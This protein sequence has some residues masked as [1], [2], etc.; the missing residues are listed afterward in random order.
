M[1]F[2]VVLIVSFI[3]LKLV[4]YRLLSKDLSSTSKSLGNP[5]N[6]SHTHGTDL[7][8]F[9]CLST[10]ERQRY[11]TVYLGLQMSISRSIIYCK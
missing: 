4:L 1:G 3:F 2:F 5:L 7:N 10:I 9:T 8:F 6:Y 11:E